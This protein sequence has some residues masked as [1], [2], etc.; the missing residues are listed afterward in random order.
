MHAAIQDA[1]EN[2]LCLDEPPDVVQ[3]AVPGSHQT[4]PINLLTRQLSKCREVSFSFRFPSK[5]LLQSVLHF[6]RLKHDF[7]ATLLSGLFQCEATKL[8]ACCAFCEYVKCGVRIKSPPWQMLSPTWQIMR[9]LDDGM[10]PTGL[11]LSGS[12]KMTTTSFGQ[13]P[14]YSIGMKSRHQNW[15][16]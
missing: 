4:S 12:P 16:R 1:T 13:L 10:E 6:L 3:R 9:T 7:P 2:A 15:S 11:P 8:A 14:V 5:D